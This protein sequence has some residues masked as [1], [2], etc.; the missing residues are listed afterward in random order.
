MWGK[1]HGKNLVALML[2][3]SIVLHVRTENP[4]TFP[5]LTLSIKRLLVYASVYTWEKILFT[6]TVYAWVLSSSILV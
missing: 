1:T 3:C 6:L 5:S 2:V 4:S